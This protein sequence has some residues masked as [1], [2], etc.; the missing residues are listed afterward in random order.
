M[1]TRLKVAHRIETTPYQRAR[2]RRLGEKHTRERIEAYQGRK[3]AA[4]AR[5]VK[6]AADAAEAEAARAEWQRTIGD[7]YLQPKT[8]LSQGERNQLELTANVG[9]EQLKRYLGLVPGDVAPT[10]CIRIQAALAGHTKPTEAGL[11]LAQRRARGLPMPW[12]GAGHAA[13]LGAPHVPRRLKPPFVAKPK[14]A[15]PNPVPSL[16]RPLTDADYADACQALDVA[17]YDVDRYLRGGKQRR[18]AR[19]ALAAWA[20]ERGLLDA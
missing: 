7:L 9:T 11:T 1:P 12:E 18:E 5:A 19:E 17:R 2:I 8:P 13:L 3:A 10:A 14:K 16:T 6:A 15:P 4:A 20:V